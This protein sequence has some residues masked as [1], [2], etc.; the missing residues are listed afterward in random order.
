MQNSIIIEHISLKNWMKFPNYNTILYKNDSKDKFIINNIQGGTESGKTS[1]LYG[2]EFALTGTIMGIDFSKTPLV[3][4]GEDTAEVKLKLLDLETSERFLLERILTKRGTQAGRILNATTKKVLAEDERLNDGILEI[5]KEKNIDSINARIL[6]RLKVFSESRFLKPY[7]KKLLDDHNIKKKISRLEHETAENKG[8]LSVLEKSVRKLRTLKKDLRDLSSDLDEL[9][10]DLKR[11]DNEKIHSQKNL[12]ESKDILEKIVTH[13]KLLDDKKEWEKATTDN[14]KKI[15]ENKQSEIKNLKKEISELVTLNKSL[16]EEVSAKNFD[17]IGE[18][19][20]SLLDKKR[21]LKEN[22]KNEYTQRDNAIILHNKAKMSIIKLMSKDLSDIKIKHLK[23]EG[24]D[25]QLIEE[26]VSKKENLINKQLEELAKKKKKNSGKS[27]ISKH[28]MK[29]IEI[30]EKTPELMKTCVF[31]DSPCN[32]FSVENLKEKKDDLERLRKNVEKIQIQI[33]EKELYLSK[34][35]L[36]KTEKKKATKY[37]VEWEKIKDFIT[38]LERKLEKFSEKLNILDKII[39]EKFIIQ[40]KKEEIKSNDVSIKKI[41]VNIKK[42]T[43]EIK[44]LEKIFESEDKINKKVEKI[45]EKLKKLNLDDIDVTKISKKNSDFMKDLEV[46]TYQIEEKEDS[47]GSI[48]KKIQLLEEKI[49]ELEDIVKERDN[50]IAEN[51]NIEV[52]LQSILTEKK[53]LQERGKNALKNDVPALLSQLL[54]TD[55]INFD[56]EKG[57][58]G[59]GNSIT[60]QTD[61]MSE[62]TEVIVLVSIL[63]V[64]GAFNSKLGF[65]IIDS[66]QILDE[67]ILERL[68]QV[69]QKAKLRQ[70][71][72]TTTT[73]LKKPNPYIKTQSFDEIMAE[74]TNEIVK[75][76]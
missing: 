45:N 36:V 22:I 74:T 38:N 26:L 70:F 34:I 29:I 30:V 20:E 19:R 33:N 39:N 76:R 47:K 50:I 13:R 68:M 64:L 43:N 71:I 55:V 44:Q 56:I 60:T 15:I 67:K 46:V 42:T 72:I 9:K 61:L 54:H 51:K 21:E 41:E 35:R 2:I 17:E 58:L 32:I 10:E 49:K 59:R 16:V 75:L 7:A 23:L 25:L 11:L 5:S 66:T 24:L 62:G 4:A 12:K 37:G 69:L 1:I 18:T 52:E 57:L 8:K 27:E 73:Y 6:T 31:S 53:D 28:L 3:F 40:K 63:K 14:A 65:L 48:N